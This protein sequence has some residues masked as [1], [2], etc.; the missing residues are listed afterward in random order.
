LPSGGALAGW[1]SSLSWPQPRLKEQGHERRGQARG[2]GRPAGRPGC[3]ASCRGPVSR[4]VVGRATL[5]SRGWRGGRCWPTGRAGSSGPR[6]PTCTCSGGLAARSALRPCY[7]TIRD[8]TQMP[9]TSTRHRRSWSVVS[10]P[11]PGSARVRSA[12]GEDRAPVA[13]C[14]RDQH[15]CGCRSAATPRCLPATIGDW[16]WPDAPGLPGLDP[17]RGRKEP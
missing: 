7:T 1:L 5:W 17:R 10:C 11:P 16:R 15:R 12:W 4:R 6:R 9:P 2:P 8:S 14:R 3:C 13:G